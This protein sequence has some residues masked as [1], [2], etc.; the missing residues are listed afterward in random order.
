[1]L[2]LPNLNSDDKFASPDPQS[3]QQAPLGFD[4][5]I[6]I[7]VAFAAIG[8]I[9][10]W[11]LG[12]NPQG[13]QLGNASSPSPSPSVQST[14]PSPSGQLTATPTPQ[15]TEAVPLVVPT[16]APQALITVPSR[17]R[18]TVPAPVVVPLRPTTP[19]TPTTS[20]AVAP[21]VTPATT[22]PSAK[23]INFNDVPDDYWARPFIDALSAREIVNGFPGNSFRP[24]QLVTRA[25][26]AALVQEAFDKNPGESKT[27]YKDIPSKFWANPAIDRA[28]KTGFLKGYPG[29]IFKPN[30]QIP[31]AQVIVSLASGLNL[32]TPASATTSSLLTY[33]DANQIPNYATAKIAAATQ[34]GLVV[35]HPNTQNLNPNRN[36]TRAEVAAMV[37][38]A[39]VHQGK[40]EPIE[41]TYIVPSKP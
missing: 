16:D 32:P 8:A 22:S 33:N 23:P 37:Y 5:F 30:Q 29:N 13:F 6:G 31:K 36:A 9:L 26:Y 11:L 27:I 38:Q 2:L 12:R 25:E 3:S 15:T 40:L 19:E 10:F 34:A 1:M 41:S 18:Q 4:E 39:L 20:A 7:F 17:I 14:T 21:P 24:D 28:T 35:N